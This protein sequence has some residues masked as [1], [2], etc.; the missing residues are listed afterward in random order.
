M[1]IGFDLDKIFINYPPFIPEELIDKLYKKKSNGVLEYRI[2]SRPEQIFRLITHYSKFRPPITKNINQLKT[3]PRDKN[4]YFLI[5]GRFGFLKNKTEYIV[6]KYQIE[7]FFDGMYFNFENKQPHF[8]KDKSIKNLKINRYIDDDLPLL[9]FLARENKA[10][11]FYWLNKK[12][13]RKIKE[14]LY[15]TTS[16]SVILK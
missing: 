2:P 3:L 9:K 7:E 12:S 10:V 15:A 6:R 11:L 8:F 16:L 4:E 5:S 1:N 13:N 14:N